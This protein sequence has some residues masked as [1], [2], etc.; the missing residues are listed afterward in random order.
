MLERLKMFDD[1]KFKKA[2]LVPRTESIPVPE[3][4]EYFDGK[5]EWTIRGLDGPE[6]CNVKEAANRDV[7]AQSL[8]SAIHGSSAE[9]TKAFRDLFG[10]G[11][12]LTEEYSK[13]I[14]TLIIASVDPVI[15][16]DV[17]VKIAQTFPATMDMIT[18]KVYQLTGLGHVPGKPKG[19]GKTQE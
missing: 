5:A 12:D 6:L 9:K 3:L 7:T 2:K 11:D 16:R 18:D 17:A 4:K 8:I 10:Y 1:K 15:T 13:R 14:A 19:S